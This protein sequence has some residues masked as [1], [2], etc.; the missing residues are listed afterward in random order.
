VKGGL[1]KRK[2]VEEAKPQPNATPLA[3]NVAEAVDSYLKSRGASSDKP[4]EPG[5]LSKYRVLL[6][7]RLVPYC[8]AQGITSIQH[9]ENVVNCKRFIESWGNMR[10]NKGAALGDGT[11]RIHVERFRTFL[12]YCIDAEWLKKSGASS[13]RVKVRSEQRRYG[14]ELVEYQ[15]VLAV[16][17]DAETKV[18]VELMRWTGMRISDAQKFR[19]QELVPNTSKTGWN[20]DFIQKKTKRR[21]IVPVPDHVVAQLRSLPQTSTGSFFKSSLG[22]MSDKVNTL[23]KKAQAVNINGVIADR[24]FKHHVSPHCLR[25]T[26]AIQNLNADVD[27][28]LVSR[29]LGHESVAITQ[30]HYRNELESTKLLAEEIS[31]AAIAKMLASTAVM[32]QPEAQRVIH[33]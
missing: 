19:I 11:K 26:F 22:V 1:L 2:K 31:R 33:R 10:F 5:T 13:I 12:R 23:F 27:I 9:F 30:R 32:A 24:T 29:W 28:A 7:N 17:H 4:I 21:C 3:V 16:A 14:L 6:R 18:A 15:R 20:A 8:A 25:H